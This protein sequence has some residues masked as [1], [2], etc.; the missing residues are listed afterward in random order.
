MPLVARISG[1]VKRAE[2]AEALAE[3][4]VSVPGGFPYPATVARLG[5]ALLAVQ[6]GD[7]TAAGEQYA[8]LQ[9]VPSIML[10]LVSTD[11]VLGLLCTTMGQL[12]QA[13]A[14]FEASLDFCRRAGYRPELAW[15][16]C[17]YADT[18][19][20]RDGDG[21]REKA[22]SL[23]DESLAISR[24]LGM[25][26]LMERVTDRFA[27]LASLPP[28]PPTYP[29]GLTE[30]EVEVLRLIA[31]GK[32][33]QEIGEE[34]FISVRTVANHVSSILNKTSSANRTE[35][36]MYASRHELA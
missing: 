2:E 27:R 31:H 17:D 3:S 30:R 12:D 9:S 34:L 6:R 26:P 10:L 19:H 20:E 1:E 21:D 28:A 5:L 13:A 36:A 29:G 35:A 7:A 25:R 14:H 23:L 24:D 8:A 22:V 18:L 15:A 16:C 4:V 11:R 33:N 32:T